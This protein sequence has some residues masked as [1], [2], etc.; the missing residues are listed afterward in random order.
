MPLFK[1]PGVEEKKKK[2]KE[3]AAK[4]SKPEK[5]KKS[6]TLIDKIQKADESVEQALG[7][8]RNEY[9]LIRDEKTL[10]DYID[11]CIANDVI[12]IDTET[13]GLDPML[14]A[15]VGICIYTPDEKAAYIPVNHVSYI[16]GERIDNQLTEDQIHPHF[17]R[18]VE[19][20]T[21]VIMFNAAFDIRVLRNHINVY[22]T[23]FW[24]AYIASKLLNENEPNGGLKALHQKYILKDKEDE[25][26]FGALFSGMTFDK[27]PINTAYMYAAHDA[28]VTYELYKYQEKYLC[29]NAPRP[30]LV[31]VYHL[32]RDIEMPVIQVVCDMEDRGVALDF[33]VQRTL[34]VKYN[35]LV[36]EKLDACHQ[37]LAKYE[38]EIN[39]YRK[40]HPD[41]DKLEDPIN[42]DSPTQ[43]AILYYD[44]LKTPV[45][46]KRK[47]RGTGEEILTKIGDPLSKAILE[48]RGV[49]KLLTTYID[50]MPN[51][52]NPNDGRIHCKFNQYGAA[53]G[54]F[55]SSDPNLQNIPSHNKEIRQLFRGTIEEEDIDITDSFRTHQYHKLETVE[56]IKFVKDLTT[57]DQVIAMSA[58]GKVNLPI[59]DV[60][61]NDDY[62]TITFNNSNPVT[63][64]LLKPFI[65][66]SSDFSQQ[67]P[68][69]MT[70]M[71]GD[72]QMIK[73]YQE[74]KDLYSEIA[75][76]A[77][78]KSYEDCLEFY[79]DENG[80]KTDK[81]NK[82]GKNRRSQAKSILLGVLYGR[83]E[84]SIAE[85]LGCSVEE[86][87]A[88]KE[89]VFKGFPAIPKFEQDSINMAKT[90]GYVTTLWGRKRR[91]PDLQLPEY[92]F[93]WEDGYTPNVDLLDFETEVKVTPVPRDKINSYTNKLRRARKR[94]EKNAIIQEAK[95]KDHIV[96]T[97]NS[98]KIA[99]A[100]RQCV[101]SRIQGSAAD[102]SKKAMI[103]VGN[104]QR[105]KELGFHILIPVHD[106]LIGECPI[107]NARECEHLFAELM[108]TCATDKLQIPISC[109][110]DCFFNWYGE[111]IEL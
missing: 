25:F 106:E 62:V 54:R 92:S 19:N 51:A 34:S 11:R 108:S 65:M 81:T 3:I 101:N 107:E 61:H 63:L 93:K 111:K 36:E 50:K 56:G 88:I 44:I 109:D 52:A 96:I 84:A 16:T 4:I 87:R 32:F 43:L 6:N 30:D 76:L 22:L 38:N 37:E 97:Q 99:D 26:S 77:F 21:K 102:M 85:Q 18:L 67:E 91:L 42:I 82:E 23:C 15:L 46:D 66:M 72:P 78:H 45:K 73:A 47:P 39:A 13:T 27:I 69:V 7:S 17:Q 31:D 94:D 24:D 59:K 2:D 89:S 79:L 58:D 20:N 12:S 41:D 40:Q 8:H 86:A 90:K 49:R 68:K 35:A 55:S 71:C 9:I 74:G 98:M 57:S 64:H 60:S 14:D 33:D 83:Q 28:I 48:Y 103:A 75:S 95:E 100:T 10:S 29:E 105:L 104:N 70:Q 53:T 1:I 80:K 110:V 5:V